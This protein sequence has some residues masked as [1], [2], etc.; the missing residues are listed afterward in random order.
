MAME[1]NSSDENGRYE[2]IK[3]LV[4]LLAFPGVLAFDSVGFARRARKLRP[5]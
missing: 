4:R 3:S 1:V 2:H 5:Q